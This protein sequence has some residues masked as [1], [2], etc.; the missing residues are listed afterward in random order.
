M[1]E[2]LLEDFELFFGE[3]PANVR[4]DLLF[5][6]VILSDE[7]FVFY[8]AREVYERAGRGLFE[9]ETRI[10]RIG[11]LIN[12]V[13]VLDVYFAMNVRNRFDVK[14]TSRRERAGG[15]GA[16]TARDCYAHE[17][18]AIRT[19]KQRWLEL[20]ATKFTPAAIAAALIPPG[21][22]QKRAPRPS[23]SSSVHLS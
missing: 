15:G 11:N 9:A 8:D 10:G 12:A 1:S 23:T 18:D 6:M 17:I 22:P 5:M 13:S 7:N 4:E 2:S 16:K 20:R 21:P 14:N 19:A 3:L